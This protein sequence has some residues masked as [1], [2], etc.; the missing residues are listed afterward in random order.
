MNPMPNKYAQKKG[1]RVPK[2]HYKVSNWQKYNE[3]LRNRGNIEIWITNEAIENWYTKDRVYDGTGSTPKYTD[4]AIITCHEVR[5]VFKLPLRQNQGFIDSIFALKKLSIR[6]PDYSCLSKRLSVLG[7]QSPRYKKTDKPDETVA[8]IAI[9]S[10]GLKRFGRDE[11]HQ[12]KHKISANRSWRKLHIVVDDHHIIHGTTLTDK[13]VSDDSAIDDLIKQVT[14]SVNH[15]TADGA[16]DKNPVYD[17]LSEKFDAADIIIPPH[18]DA[19]YNTNS[20]H[21]R[22]RNLQEIKTFGRMNWQRVREYGKRNYAELSIQ[23][24]KKILGN[25]LHARKLSRQKNETMIGCGV[26]NKMTRLGMPISHKFV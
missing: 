17:K 7:I 18:S 12:E 11:W 6:C 25:K 20:H 21:Q 24:Y 13:F 26:L 1:W 5:Q 10:T 9:D 8:A 14:I 3:A 4:L 15:V 19:V 16:Y 23:R 2:Q 22:N